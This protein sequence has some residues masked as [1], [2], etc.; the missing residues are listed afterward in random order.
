MSEESLKNLRK[1]ISF[2]SLNMLYCSGVLFI[3][4]TKLDCL[5]NYRK[6]LGKDYQPPTMYS[7]YISNHTCWSVYTFIFIKD[8]FYIASKYAPGFVSKDTMSKIPLFGLIA[9]S[10]QSTFLDRSSKE[11]RAEAVIFNHNFSLKLL[12]IV[13]Q[14]L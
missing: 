4:E 3:K 6:Y 11:K 7:S 8:I 12:L 2:L 9:N 1:I 5:E 10:A 13:T 14:Q